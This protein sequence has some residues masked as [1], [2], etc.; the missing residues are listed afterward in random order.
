MDV[1][2]IYTKD[3]A[4][5]L[6]GS[7]QQSKGISSSELT[8][9]LSRSKNYLMFKIING[10]LVI[11]GDYRVVLYPDGYKVDDEEVF[12]VYSTGKIKE[13]LDAGKATTTTIEQRK[14]VISINN[15]GQTMEIG[16]WC[17]PFC[18]GG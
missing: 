17:P 16:N 18:N 5:K 3:E 15:G 12:V 9:L 14:D 10:Q 2:K 8:S 1:G 4:D 6:Y 7:V 11:L 13:L